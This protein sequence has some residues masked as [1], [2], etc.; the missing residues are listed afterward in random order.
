MTCPECMDPMRRSETI[1]Y[2]NGTK[3]FVFVCRECGIEIKT[4]VRS[5]GSDGEAAQ[6]YLTADDTPVAGRRTCWGISHEK[7][8]D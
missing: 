4:P 8:C 1:S 2:E 7:F 6:A 5:G 3:A